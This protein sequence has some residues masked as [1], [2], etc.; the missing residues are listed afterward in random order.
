[1][2]K[3]WISFMVASPSFSKAPTFSSSLPHDVS[4]IN[5][6]SQFVDARRA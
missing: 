2:M 3:Y 1:M 5:Y 4:F 6:V